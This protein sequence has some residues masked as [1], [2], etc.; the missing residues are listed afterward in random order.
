MKSEHRHELAENDLGKLLDRSR[1]HIEPYSNKILISLLVATVLIVG[2][3]VIYRTQASKSMVG[4][5]ELAEAKTPAEYDTVAEQFPE[6]ETGQWARLRAGQGHLREGI[7]LSLTNR[8]ASND[9]LEQAQKSL[10]LALR[11]ENAPSEVR[12]Q[13]LFSLAV[14]LESL[15]SQQTTTKPAIEAYERF[16]SEFKESRF[17]K[18]AEE[19]IAALKSPE[20]EQ[21]YT[22]FHAQNPKPEDRPRPMDFNS[23][24]FGAPTDGGTPADMPADAAPTGGAAETGPSL[25]LPATDAPATTPAVEIPATEPSTPV[26]DPA[27]PAESGAEPPAPPAS[28]RTGTP[29]EPAVPQSPAE[30]T[31]TTE[32]PTTEPSPNP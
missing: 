1:D 4:A 18:R 26:T 14:C 9:S 19:R 23:L 3:I 28:E 27:A 15:S 12:E 16:L 5:A 13:A 8:S 30:A 21:F 31:P 10:D 24:P 7:R 32:T 17:R 11:S 25:D 6:T 20:A 2:G 22:W 29:T